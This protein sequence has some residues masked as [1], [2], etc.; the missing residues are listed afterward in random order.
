MGDTHDSTPA[1]VRPGQMLAGKYRVDRVL[2]M[3]GMGVVVQATHA[4]LGQRVALKFMLPSALGDA[5][6]VGRFLR[7]ARAAVRLKSEHVARVLDVGS[8]D[9]GAP[10]IVMEF[11][12][13]EDIG[14]LV[15]RRGALPVAE[16]TELVLQACEAL[17]EAHA[18]GIVHRDLKPPNLF[19]TRAAD[20]SPVVK[21]LDFGISK[22]TDVAD[23]QLALTRTTAVM[24]S[25]LYMSP[26]QMK[27]ARSVDAR[28]DI[29]SLGVILHELTTAKVP[30]EAD[31]L[32]S[33]MAQVLA[34]EPVRSIEQMRADLGGAFGEVVARCLEKDRDKRYPNVGDLAAALAPFAPPHALP[35]VD[36]IRRVQGLVPVAPSSVSSHPSP[37]SSTSPVAA[38]TTRTLAPTQ[39]RGGWWLVFAGTCILLL[40]ASV[41]VFVVRVRSKARAA[42]HQEPPS[43]SLTVL[44]VASESPPAPS[45][46]TAHAAAPTRAD[47]AVELEASAP[48]TAPLHPAQRLAPQPRAS[49]A[50]PSAE[51]TSASSPAVPPSPPAPSSREIFDRN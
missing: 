2:G 35:L 48:R 24:G 31:S 9:D 17:A 38:S 11:L 29:W 30:F 43:S 18:L 41:V 34:P 26:E 21:V 44:S 37:H 27:S 42:A 33:L 12:E 32:G 50:R 15:R 14:A 19:L 25:P 20:G 23:A 47:A 7:E 16:T 4:A 36:R 46:V 8:L 28:S 51:P 39:R 13:G 6:A 22:S 45:A 1:P 10:Y 3:G 5:E 40:L 49:Q